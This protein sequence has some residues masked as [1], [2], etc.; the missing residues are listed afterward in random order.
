MTKGFALIKRYFKAR[1]VAKGFALIEMIKSVWFF[2]GI[3]F[4]YEDMHTASESKTRFFKRRNV[5]NTCHEFRRF[6]QS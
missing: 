1:L 6:L 4:H 3:V 5:F 2:L